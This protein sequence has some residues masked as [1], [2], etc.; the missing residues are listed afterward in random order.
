MQHPSLQRKLPVAL[1]GQPRIQTGRALLLIILMMSG[2]LVIQTADHSV[3][4]ASR[5]YA[6]PLTTFSVEQQT[7]PELRHDPFSVASQIDTL[8]LREVDSQQF[9]G[10]VLVAQNGQIVL[11]KGYSLANQESAIYNIPD[12]RFYLGSIT[13]TFT[14]MAILLLQEQG[15]LH[16]QDQLCNYIPNC[17]S[18]WQAVSIHEMLTHTSGIPQL[19]DSQI[20][21]ASP[22]AWIASFTNVPLQFTPGGAF[23]YCSICYQILAYVV[24]QVSGEP[25]SQF[26]QQNILTPL[27]MT[28]SGFDSQAY[29]SQASSALGYESWR[30]RSGPIGF[31]TDPQWSVLLGSGLLYAT[32]N[33]LYRW[34]Q[35]L[36]TNTL[37]SQA[38]LA[39]IFT[40]YVNATIFPGSAYGYG[41]FLTSSPVT[42]HQLTWHDGVVDG[43]RNYIGRYVNDGVT[44][45][46]LSNLT[47][48]DVIPLAHSIEQIIFGKPSII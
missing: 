24:Q 43:F 8:L 17:P 13:K 41:W 48:L 32:V 26:I 5:H 27:H 2:L 19:D 29:Y 28:A 30:V 3:H 6:H 46:I 37:V 14:A 35:A 34:D 25:Y 12:T 16:V 4:G 7:R 1:P 33:D 11:N 21:S 15:K 47:T 39:Q 22:A 18:P 38:T 40:P 31:T 45:I 9:S 42:G 23:Q 20:S 10:S 36:Y 44:I